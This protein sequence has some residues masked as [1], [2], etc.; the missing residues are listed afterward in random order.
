MYRRVLS[1]VI[2]YDTIRDIWSVF[3][4]FM[5]TYTQNPLRSIECS[6]EGVGL[7]HAADSAAA[8]A[9]AALSQK[10]KFTNTIEIYILKKI[11]HNTKIHA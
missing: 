3:F 8:A 10:T 7:L 6:H 2:A 5:N 11:V 1:K 4:S 9:A